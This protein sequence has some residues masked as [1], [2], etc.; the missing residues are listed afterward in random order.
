MIS[1]TA[2]IASAGSSSDPLV[3]MEDAIF[4]WVL[5]GSGYDANHVIWG[6]RGPVPHG[7]YVAMMIG[8]SRRVSGDWITSERTAGDNILHHVGGT[9]HPTLTLTAFAGAN[10]GSGMPDF[11]L[12]R[13]IAAYKLPSVSRRLK[14]GGVG[15]GT[16]GPI[17]SMDGM[18]GTMYDP[19]ASMDITLHTSVGLTVSEAGSAIERA[20]ATTTTVADHSVAVDAP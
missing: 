5:V 7:P 16:I 3:A 11:V 14:S 8:N 1:A 12:N 17:R 20:E 10:N 19:R 4:N 6:D 15:V 9:R 13:V 18:R 2:T